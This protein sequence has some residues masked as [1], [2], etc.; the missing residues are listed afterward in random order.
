MTS[1][2]RLIQSIEKRESFLKAQ[3]AGGRD[4]VDLQGYQV[5][6]VIADIKAIPDLDAESAERLTCTINDGTWTGPQKHTILD[7][8]SDAFAACDDAHA[9]TGTRSQ[10]YA[11]YPELSDAK[12]PAY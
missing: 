12:G 3:S 11:E 7:A 9:K 8:I 1:I 6:K 2:D 4:T 10:Q 5:N